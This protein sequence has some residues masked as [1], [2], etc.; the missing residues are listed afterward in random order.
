M[1]KLVGFNSKYICS[2]CKNYLKA[3][4]RLHCLTVCKEFTRPALPPSLQTLFCP[5]NI[6]P[7]LCIIVFYFIS[8][9][10]KVNK[11]L[12][13]LDF[14]ICLFVL[15]VYFGTSH[16]P[17]NGLKP[18]PTKILKIQKSLFFVKYFKPN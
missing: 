14:H 18:K 1:V 10:L 16:G 3:G 15:S 6:T 17:R 11:K 4:H 8:V 5:K 12:I 2:N 9:Y 13:S 7:P